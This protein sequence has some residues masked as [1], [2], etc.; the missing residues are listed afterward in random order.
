MPSSTHR[1]MLIQFASVK[2]ALSTALRCRVETL[3]EA[4]GLWMVSSCVV[5]LGAQKFGKRSPQLRCELNP[6]V[7]RD[8]AGQAKTRDPMEKKVR[9]RKWQKKYR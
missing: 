5:Q 6:S 3:D 2:R 1:S 8:I 7:R 9:G 4:V